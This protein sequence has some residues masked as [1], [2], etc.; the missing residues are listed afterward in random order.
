MHRTFWKQIY[1][2][3]DTCP[4]SDICLRR[5]LKI[6][7]DSTSAKP[8]STKAEQCISMNLKYSSLQMIEPYF[9]LLCMF[10]T[11]NQHKLQAL[12]SRTRAHSR[13]F[14]GIERH[15]YARDHR[16]WTLFLFNLKSHRRGEPDSLV[17]F[18]FR[19]PPLLRIKTPPLPVNLIKQ[20]HHTSHPSKPISTYNCNM[21]GT[22]NKPGRDNFFNALPPEVREMIFGFCDLAIDD[23]E[24][25]EGIRI[26]HPYDRALVTALRPQPSAY[27]QVLSMFFKQNRFQLDEGNSWNFS[28]MTSITRSF[29]TKL[30]IKLP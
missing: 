3:R 12:M 14:T 2:T 16:H 8:I 22:V 15:V 28:C 7:F 19:P 24:D 20:H 29:I 13:R 17:E 30:T 1:L 5:R 23:F 11:N 27:Q 18:T 9:V 26:R 6:G 21:S 10:I 25:Y 4:I